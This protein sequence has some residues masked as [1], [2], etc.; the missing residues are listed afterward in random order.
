M[1]YSVLQINDSASGQNFTALA[2]EGEIELVPGSRGSAPNLIFGGPQWVYLSGAKPAVDA[3]IATG[4]AAGT[5]MVVHRIPGVNSGSSA[6]TRFI[7]LESTATTTVALSDNSASQDLGAGQYVDVW[8][9]SPPRIDA[10]QA[11]NAATNAESAAVM[12]A[13]STARA[14]EGVS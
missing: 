12:Q 10:A 8:E 5:K 6:R 3:G 9:S 1:A 2:E 13:V 11:F 14:S 4:Q 7:V